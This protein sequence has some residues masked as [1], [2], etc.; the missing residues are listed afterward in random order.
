MIEK[1]RTIAEK[2]G[3]S[4]ELPRPEFGDVAIPCFKAKQLGLKPEELARKIEEELK[5]I[6]GIKKTEFVGGFLNIWLDENQ[7]LLF[8]KNYSCKKKREKVL[9]EHASINPNASPHIGRARNAIIGDSLSRLLKFYGYDVERHYYVNDI[10]KQVAMLALAASGKESFDQMLEVYKQAA[11]RI[12]K[13]EEFAKKVNEFLEKI[14]QND[15]AAIKKIKRIVKKC[16]AGQ[17]AILKKIGVSF[18]FFDYESSFLQEAKRMVEQFYREKKLLKDKE[19]KLVFDL[20]GSGLEIGMKEPFVALTRPNGTTLY[21]TRDIAYTIWKLKR[22][23]QN[24]IVLGEDQ[25]LYFKQLSYIL[26]SL[27]FEAPKVIHYSMVLVRVGGEIRKMSTRA[28]TYV[29]LEGF[30]NLIK[31]RLAEEAR[32]RKS[33]ISEREI[34]KLASNVVR[35]TIAKIDYDKNVIFDVEEATRLIGNTAIY[36]N[37][38][39]ARAKSILKKLGKKN[40]TNANIKELGHFES[41]LLHQLFLFPFVLEN[42]V[43]RLDIS[44]I[45]KYSYELCK[46]F[47]DFYENCPVV[48]AEKEEKEKRLALL[49]LFI[50]V[51]ESCFSI[52]G[53][54]ALERI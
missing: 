40:K 30:F 34:E 37:Y 51:L 19:G 5:K 49:L 53:L 10:G 14:E 3:L 22:A 50:K 39:L 12:E 54:H 1:I 7:K 31:D 4:L 25:K 8:V 36:L 43:K 6:G 44:L 16:V 24:I 48:T 33:S 13:D 15:T 23:K 9:I 2:F 18:D 28:G 38:S 26:K 52:L 35:Y 32:Q 20:R 27:G 42:A 29:L 45:A 17:R 47:N 21:L 46:I 41:L 11:E